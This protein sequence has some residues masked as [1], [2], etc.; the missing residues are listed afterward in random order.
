M[1]N[2]SVNKFDLRLRGRFL[3]EQK[4]TTS[5]IEK[6]DASLED[7]SNNMEEI[8]LADDDSSE[9]DNQVVE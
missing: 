4:I 7:Q 3:K 8:A 6:N 2:K 5:E 1:D 9:D